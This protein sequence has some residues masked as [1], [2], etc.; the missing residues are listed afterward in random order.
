MRASLAWA[1]ETMV[2]TRTADLQSWGSK[3]GYFTTARPESANAVPE[4]YD[5]YMTRRTLCALPWLGSAGCL[6]CD[7]KGK[8]LWRRELGRQDH[9]WGYGSS[10]ILHGGLV[11]LNFGPGDPSFL[12]AMDTDSGKTEWKVELTP[13]LPAEDVAKAGELPK[14]P[15]GAVRS[16]FF[17]SWTTPVVVR[18]SNR[19][20]M[21]CNLARRVVAFDPKTGRELW[22]F[23]GFPAP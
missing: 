14:R 2:R 1:A 5:P 13:R 18:A 7:T 9:V 11:V 17:G 6:A 15:D 21:V 3:N 19:D 10:P 23:G 4:R 8:E 16:D 22:T 20:E 12:V